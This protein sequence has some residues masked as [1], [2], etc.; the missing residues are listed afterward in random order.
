KGRQS[1]ERDQAWNRALLAA[2]PRPS[3]KDPFEP[4]RPSISC[5]RLVPQHARAVIFRRALFARADRSRQISRRNRS[6]NRLNAESRN[7]RKPARSRRAPAREILLHYRE[8]LECVR[9][10]AWRVRQ[11]LGLT[12]AHI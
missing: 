12:I 4:Q 5:R 6:K 11:S 8:T 3:H 9:R 10:L 2:R 1:S 7:H